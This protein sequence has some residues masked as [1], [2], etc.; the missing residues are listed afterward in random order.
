MWRVKVKRR[1]VVREAVNCMRAVYMKFGD[2]VTEKFRKI[3]GKG[4]GGIDLGALSHGAI[5][6]Q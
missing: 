4:R 1:K 6:M 2:F 3:R 5:Y